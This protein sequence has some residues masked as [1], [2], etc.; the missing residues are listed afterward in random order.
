MSQ[1]P[2]RPTQSSPA[3]LVDKRT[4]PLSEIEDAI[5]SVHFGTVQI[6]I[7]DSVVVQIDKT[8]KLRLR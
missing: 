2:S 3:P 8:E 5:R 1:S 7:Q 6:V 4:I